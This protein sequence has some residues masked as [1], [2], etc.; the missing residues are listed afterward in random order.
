MFRKIFLF[1]VLEFL[2]M[3]TQSMDGLEKI[4]KIKGKKFLFKVETSAKANDY[5]KYE[6]LRFG[7]WGEPTDTL[8]GER[9][10]ICENFL[11]EGSSL[12]IAVYVADEKEQF[13][14]DK[15]HFIGFS[16][17]FVGLKDKKVGFRWTDNLLFFSQ[18]TAVRSDFQAY[19]LGILIKEFQ[20]EKIMDMFGIYTITCT[21]DPLTGINA[22]RN[23]HHFGME[24]EEYREACYGDFGGYLNRPDVPCDRFFVSWDLRKEVKRPRYELEFLVDSGK[25]VLSSDSIEVRGRRGQVKLEVV[26]AVNLD[27]DSDFLLVEIPYDFYFM[28]RE[29][30]VPQ[31]RIRNIPLDWRLKSRK[32]F[33]TYLERRYKI[34][35]FRAF[36]KDNRTRDFYVLQRL[37][38]D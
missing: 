3:N 12:F 22:Y 20:K 34:V 26:K 29:T 21:Y 25:L 35:D 37:K 1:I 5:A 32:V 28:L 17:G 38:C 6:E 7:I 27:L 4:Q 8:P 10:M 30:D 14:E 16:Y 15:E 31:K 24:V 2:E 19:G 9:N 11:H 36:E 33:Q 18:Y 23:I 13:R